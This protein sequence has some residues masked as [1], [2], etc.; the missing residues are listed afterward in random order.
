MIGAMPNTAEMERCRGQ[1][2]AVIGAP[3]PPELQ[4]IWKD[5]FGIVLAGGGSYGLD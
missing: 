1:I 4:K 3:F 2:R 5:R